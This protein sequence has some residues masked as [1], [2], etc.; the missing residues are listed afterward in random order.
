MTMISKITIIVSAY[1]V[2]KSEPCTLLLWILI[3]C[4]S[5]YTSLSLYL[6][7]LIVTSRTLCF[8]VLD[9][10]LLFTVIYPL[11]I[12]LL[13]IC[14]LNIWIWIFFSFQIILQVFKN[15]SLRKT[16]SII[17]PALFSID[18]KRFLLLYVLLSYFFILAHSL[19]LSSASLF[20]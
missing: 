12:S 16:C 4:S 10:V 1:L 11:F 18:F 17:F 14:S 6:G 19:H 8:S 5:F 15:P 13:C 2:N 3:G 20:F 9:P 7:V